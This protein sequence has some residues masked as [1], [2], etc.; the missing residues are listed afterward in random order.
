M[1]YIAYTN[2]TQ[3]LT[4]SIEDR[5]LE[6]YE[7]SDKE[8]QKIYKYHRYGGYRNIKLIEIMNISSTLFMIFFIQIIFRCIDYSGLS[9][10]SNQE[11]G[12]KY[13][14][15]YIYLDKF[16][17]RSFFNICFLSIFGVYI[18]L[19]IIG[20]ID[21]I[22]QYREV[23]LFLESKL[24]INDTLIIKISWKDLCS[25]LEKYLDLNTYQ[26]HAKI[27][28]KENFMIDVFDSEINRFIFS[29]LMEWNLIFC[30]INPL[31][32]NMEHSKLDFI[33][34]QQNLDLDGNT[35]PESEFVEMSEINNNHKETLIYFKNK[36]EIKK[37]CFLNLV[38]LAYLT[39]LAMP[40]LIIYT[41]FF[42]FLK[43]GERYYQNP[44]K[45]TLRHWSLASNWKI[46]YYQELPHFLESRLESSSKYAKQ[47][48]EFFQ[49]PIQKYIFKFITLVCSSIF[50]SLIIL[51]V[52]NENI[53]LHLHISKDKHVL[54]YLGILAS[55]IAISRNLGKI[56]NKNK[57]IE[58]K[59]TSY[60]KIVTV[61]PFINDKN[62]FRRINPLKITKSN[63]RILCSMYV[64]QFMSLLRECISILFIPISLVYLANYIDNIIEKV[65]RNIN[66]DPQI[67][68][69]GK[70]SNFRS[71]DTNSSLKS[72]YAFREFRN[73]NP[74]WGA[75]IEIYRIGEISFLKNNIE[76]NDT[77]RD[78]GNHI[79]DNTV[80]SSL[81]II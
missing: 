34:S 53:L 68:F 18:F 3:D 15:D 44:N 81:S 70:T 55:L 46:R 9:E 51:S 58:D 8:L 78:Y 61:I 67:G 66:Y 4:E 22:K 17:E 19:R 23:K 2:E 73:Q 14:W 29:K 12:N 35:N 50:I 26:I 41:F 64:Y 45:I 72:I 11:T 80:N 37:K 75:N 69:V 31:I 1:D 40:F 42:T 7:I 49:S 38:V 10:I 63:K 43:Y 21:A 20:I 27:L 76:K 59:E 36:A 79:F 30:I 57:K 52:Y 24:H 54:W 28:R 5:L 71:L 39:F 65:E 47:Y 32:E 48:L 16:T 77:F 33:Y 56:K 60:Q 13:L 74:A 62:K 6:P 25:K